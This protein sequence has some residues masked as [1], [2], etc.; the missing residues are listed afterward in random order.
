MNQ[1]IVG[2]LR[3]VSPPAIKRLAAVETIDQ[4]AIVCGMLSIHESQAYQQKKSPNKHER[5]IHKSCENCVNVCHSAFQIK[6]G[7]GKELRLE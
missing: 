5:D 3:R 2:R 6:I 1:S 4:I 7:V